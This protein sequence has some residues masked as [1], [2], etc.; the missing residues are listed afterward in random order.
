M[1]RSKKLA[2]L[3]LIASIPIFFPGCVIIYFPFFRN[4]SEKPLEIIL[5]QP[6]H[7]N[8]LPSFISYKNELLPI[9]EK[10]NKKLTDSLPITI[11]A[12]QKIMIMVPARSTISLFTFSVNPPDTIVLKQEN[13]FDTLN[14]SRSNSANLAVFKTKGFPVKRFLYYDYN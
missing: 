11:L 6:G 1:V 3:L 8:N 13:R 2:T 7:I 4:Y 5:N 10:T 12:G 9:C 14:V